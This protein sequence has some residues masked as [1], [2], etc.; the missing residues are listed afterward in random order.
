MYGNYKI[1]SIVVKPTTRK[2]SKIK[3]IENIMKP[4]KNKTLQPTHRP[5]FHVGSMSSRESRSHDVITPSPVSLGVPLSYIPSVLVAPVCLTR[6]Q[7]D[8][9]RSLRGFAALLTL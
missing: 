2:R 6:F 9:C 3:H 4:L 1:V 5:E 8:R 7:Q